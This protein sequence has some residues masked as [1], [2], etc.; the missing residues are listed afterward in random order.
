VTFRRRCLGA[1]AV[2]VVAVLSLPATRAMPSA[3]AA[4]SG[5]LTITQQG[6]TLLGGSVWRA[7][8]DTGGAT[9]EDLMLSVSSHRRLTS[10]GD[11][12]DIDN[13]DLGDRLDRMT[14]DVAALPRNEQGRLVLSVPTSPSVSTPD[15]LL[16]GTT[17]VYP[18]SLEL[19]VDNQPVS[20]AVTLVH[21]VTSEDLPDIAAAGSLRVMPVM[22]LAS[23]PAVVADGSVVTDPDFAA[24]VQTLVDSYAGAKVG[25]YVALPAGQASALAA[26]NADLVGALIGERPLHSFSATTFTPLDASAMATAELAE[27]YASQLRAGEDATALALGVTPDRTT[28]VINEGLTADGATLL[29]D[30]GTRG[31]ILTPTALAASGLNGQLD[32]SLT[33]RARATDGSTLLVQ[34][35]DETFAK[36]LTRTEL[37]PLARAVRVSGG[38]VMQRSSLVGAAKDLSLVSVALG[39]PSGAPPDAQVLRQLV[40][41]TDT[42]PALAM[43]ATPVPTGTETS[44][45]LVTLPERAND[46]LM[47]VKEVMDRLEPRIN[48]TASMLGEGDLRAG[49]WR[50]MHVTLAS[51]TANEALRAGLVDTLTTETNAV[52][53]AVGLPA[54]ANFTL[55]GRESE[56]R[57][58]LRNTSDATIRVDIR[59]R[60]AKLRFPQARQ[61]VEIPAESNTEVVTMVEARSN[62]RFPVTVELVTPRGDVLLGSETVTARVSALAGLGQVVTVVAA[63]ML[64]TWWVHNWRTKRRR[65]IEN[66][67]DASGHPARKATTV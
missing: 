55:S 24:G 49:R 61:T 38:L 51:S 18:V 45:D 63:L 46:G 64:L 21:H 65:A 44:G 48:S 26:S 29:R 59:F 31:V 47:S 12:S 35:I 16:F 2:A 40:R 39:T 13:G 23:P 6:F 3:L 37:T 17:G 15:D 57:L 1:I 41:I 30:M 9:G 32:S 67:I 27:T 10:R 33:Y 43:S 62:G 14:F 58:Q 22:L 54:T 25:A 56:L 8:I 66:A 34:G 20:T 5:N 4:G 19:T 36:V 28:A 11:L 53:Q 7:V 50:L 42:D 60:S 52:R